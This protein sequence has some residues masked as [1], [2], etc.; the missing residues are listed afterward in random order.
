MWRFLTTFWFRHFSTRHL[1]I[2]CGYTDSPMTKE[3][4]IPQ[5]ISKLLGKKK[6]IT[7]IRKK[8][9]KSPSPRRFFTQIGIDHQ[10][11]IACA[12]CNNELLSTFESKQA[13]P[14][15]SKLLPGDACRAKTTLGLREQVV[16]AA[17]MFRAVAVIEFMFPER[18]GRFFSQSQREIFRKTLVPPKGVWIWMAHYTGPS[19]YTLTLGDEN[20][21]PPL[22]FIGKGLHA[23]ISVGHIALQLVALGPLQIPMI[24]SAWREAVIQ[25]FPSKG[26]EVIWP[27]PLSLDDDGFWEFC[28]RWRR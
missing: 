2:F 27:P 26:Q 22:P 7:V 3:H 9:K 28:N 5:W 10:V 11:K 8:S 4:V 19:D 24:P 16:L 18:R 6:R 1:C 12:G 13:K 17:W 14:I 20:A 21:F 25:L 23:T 15:L